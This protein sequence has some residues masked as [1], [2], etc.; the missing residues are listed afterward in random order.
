MTIPD[1]IHQLKSDHEVHRDIRDELRWDADLTHE[2][3][4]EIWVNNGV[5]T[6]EGTAD[7]YAQRWAIEHAT[8]RVRGVRS[9]NNYLDVK[10]PK[11]E[12][13]SDRV[14]ERA[15]ANAL[16][17]DVRVP[18][19]VTATVLEGNVHLHGT[20]E[21]LADRTA[22]EE[23]VR[24]LVGVRGVINMI[25]V[26]ATEAPADIKRGIDAALRRLLDQGAQDITVAIDK[27]LVTL[28]GSVPT[29]AVR[30]DIERAVSL[31]PGVARIDDRIQLA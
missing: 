24:H 5:V 27:D 21:R 8:Y 13:H 16:E 15:V 23:A 9:V 17:W 19:G 22:A 14:L 20:V 4:V 28:T 1:S 3:A 18:R 7:S 6:L 25:Q 31:A 30:D 26:M 12:S 10:P 29:A 2:S 11:D